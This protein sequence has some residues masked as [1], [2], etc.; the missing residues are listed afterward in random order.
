MLSKSAILTFQRPHKSVCHM[1]LEMVTLVHLFTIH[2]TYQQIIPDVSVQFVPNGRN[3]PVIMLTRTC[4][5]LKEQKY[6]QARAY[7]PNT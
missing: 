2:Y 3:L 7:T 5:G 1:T 6:V 4:L